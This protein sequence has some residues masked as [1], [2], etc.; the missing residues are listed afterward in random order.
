MS[1]GGGKLSSLVSRGVVVANREMRC[2]VQQAESATLPKRVSH[3]QM[4]LFNQC[5]LKYFFSYIAGFKEPNT[6]ALTGGSITHEVVENLY[7]EPAEARTLE[8]AIELLRE[9]GKRIL[10]KPEYQPFAEDNVMK[11]SVREAVENLF[12]IE[13]P[14][15]LEVQPEHLEMNLDVMIN[16]VHFFGQVDRF[17]DNDKKRVADYKTGKSPGKFVEGKLAQPF[18]YA[19][20]FK[21][22]HG[23]DVDEVEL[24]YL[25]A[26]ER[27][28]R[29][30]KPENLADVGDKLAAMRA[31]SESSLAA[32]AWT[33]TQTKLCDWCAFQPVCPAFETDAPTPGSRESDAKLLDIGRVFRKY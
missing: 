9:H 33:A 18:L 10:E 24:L 14:Q 15:E 19:L 7:K 30:V 32:S 16:G 26:K 6:A 12:K 28:T 8:R 2:D 1:G 11:Q 5:G 29:E 4:A 25:N 23:I 31:D 27:V 20:A 22:Q 17:T 21:E 3:S 13:N